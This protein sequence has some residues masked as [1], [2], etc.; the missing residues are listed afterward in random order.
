MKKLLDIAIASRAVPRRLTCAVSVGLFVLL[1][2]SPA[3]AGLKIR[4]VFLPENAQPS[5][6]VGGG[7][8]PEIFKVAA[9]A[10]EEVF[11]SGNGSWDV[12]I[13]FGWGPL[14]SGMARVED[15]ITQGG[16][17]VRIT[18]ARVTFNNLPLSTHFFADPTPRDST[19]YKKYAS[20]L[21]DEIP[22]NLA[23][24]FSEATGDAANAIDLL[25]I[26]AHEIGHA[27]GLHELYQ[28]YEQ[29]CLPPAT[30]PVRPQQG[31]GIP[32]DEGGGLATCTVTVTAP[33]PFAG[34]QIFVDFGPHVAIFFT[35]ATALMVPDVNPGQRALISSLD[36]LLTAE[37]TSFSKP[38]LAGMLPPSR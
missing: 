22:L 28:G 37:L 7:N 33:R 11:K 18:R 23:R 16:N 12:T 26:A 34:L 25:T 14:G 17:P 3:S 9:E 5:S 13:E 36:A 1:A 15:Q 10:W 19:E 4:P 21:A 30:T 24:T 6:M 27:L 35:D 38:D 32:I 31:A 8:L 2:A 29:K 20:Y